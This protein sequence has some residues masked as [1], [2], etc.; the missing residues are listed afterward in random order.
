MLNDS[1][2][3][4]LTPD[5]KEF[6]GLEETHNELLSIREILRAFSR[7]DLSF[8]ITYRGL[9][10]GYLKAFQ[11]HLQHLIWQVRMVEE[12]D[13]TQKVEFLGEF[14]EA[15]NAM[16]SRLS[17]TLQDLKKSEETLSAQAS[18]LR[19][20]M[21]TRNT[22]M[23][24]LQESESRFKYLASYDHLTGAMNRRSFMERGIEELKNA[25]LLGI[26]CGVIMM[27]I[28]HFKNFNDTY[29]HYAGDEVLRHTV[30]IIL[31][32]SRKH[33]FLG[34]YGGEEFVLFF[35]KAD[36]PTSI[37]IAE[38][39]RKAVQNTPVPLLAGPAT[40]T[41]SFGVA[42]AEIPEDPEKVVIEEY[43]QALINNADSAMYRA[44]KEG[45]NRVIS[46]D[47]KAPDTK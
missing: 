2:T 31:S 11:S 9:V 19:N 30:K 1:N 38:R 42:M 45:R 5:L 4:L 13:F 14:S 22:A 29:G 40:I 44:K 16:T 34:R 17:T 20:E 41:V 28:D 21:E 35:T 6:P 15:F 37:I 33:D 47:N 27:D 46:F 18:L 43:L 10:H 36:A 24:R 26:S 12:G 32:L 39:I 3:P 25:F 7:G 23:E 8:P